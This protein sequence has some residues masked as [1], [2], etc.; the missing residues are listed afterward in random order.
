MGFEVN[1][2]AQG[3][4]GKFFAGMCFEGEGFAGMGFGGP[5][6]LKVEVF[7]GEV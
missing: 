6:V 2:M 1:R 4:K 7:K 5:W 3:L